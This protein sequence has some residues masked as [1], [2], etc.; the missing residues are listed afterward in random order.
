MIRVLRAADLAVDGVVAALA[1]PHAATDPDTV[2][3]VAAS[4]QSATITSA[5]G[6]RSRS[7][8]RQAPISVEEL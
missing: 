5:S 6:A 7:E 2:A 1:R 3:R 8:S 4:V